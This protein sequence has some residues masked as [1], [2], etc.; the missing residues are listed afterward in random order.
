MEV[1]G[2]DRKGVRR[3]WRERENDERRTTRKDDEEFSLVSYGEV[4]ERGGDA[5]IG[6][7][8]GRARILVFLSARDETS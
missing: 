5:Q 6:M 3:Q 7:H 1:P 2:R 4:R 8:R